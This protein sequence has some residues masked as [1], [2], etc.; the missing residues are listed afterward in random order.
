[1]NYKGWN[2]CRGKFLP[3]NSNLW[4]CCEVPGFRL[5]LIWMVSYIT[6]IYVD[7]LNYLE[8]LLQFTGVWLLTLYECSFFNFSQ[9]L[10]CLTPRWTKHFQVILLDIRMT[11]L[12]D[13]HDPGSLCR[14][15]FYSYRIYSI[16]TVI[17]LDITIIK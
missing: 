9:Y 5:F 6:Y 3:F 14:T 16:Y 10:K 13:L 4:Y 1:M 11:Y 17:F 2:Y 8:Y 15:T 12:G 7:N